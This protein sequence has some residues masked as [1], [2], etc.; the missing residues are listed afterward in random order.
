VKELIERQKA[1]EDERAKQNHGTSLSNQYPIG[2]YDPSIERQL[3]QYTEQYNEALLEAKRL[4]NEAKNLKD[5]IDLYQKRIE[6]IPKREQEL[7]ILTRDYDLM[8]TNYQSLL[9]KKIQAQMAENL[10]RKQQG[11]QFKVLDLARVPEKPIKPD[12]MRIFLIGIFMGFASGL[13]LAW[14]RESLDQS[15]HSYQEVEAY[16]GIPVI[17]TIPNLKQEERKAA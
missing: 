10:E 15:F 8:K 12:P 7:A 5:Q 1:L 14:F 13:G 3:I 4:R 2:Q 9:D 16:L 6:D 17:A 11:E